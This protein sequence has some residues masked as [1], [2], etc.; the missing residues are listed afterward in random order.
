MPDKKREIPPPRL[1]A[2]IREEFFNLPNMLT[3]ARILL[4]PVVYIIL[5]KGTPLSGFWAAVIYGV[6]T[7]TD[8]FDGYLARRQ[9]LVSLVG[10]FLD[11]LADKLI[12]MAM[13]VVLL[14]LDRISDWV[15]ILLVARELIIT[16]LR[17]VASAEGLVIPASMGGKYKAALQMLAVLFLLIHYPYPLDIIFYKTPPVDYHKVGTILIWASVIL[18]VHSAYEYFDKFLKA[19]DKQ[20]EDLGIKRNVKD[21]K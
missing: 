16:S 1:P 18:S 3:M 2:S 11:P 17:A 14:Q 7:S 13:L 12:I 15:V 9:N 8:Y 5:A 21:I 10:K 6:A 20:K 4:I 19:L